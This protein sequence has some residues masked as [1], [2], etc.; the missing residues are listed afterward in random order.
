M[1]THAPLAT[2]VLVLDRVVEQIIAPLAH[3]PQGGLGVVVIGVPQ[4]TRAQPPRRLLLYALQAPILQVLPY[5][6]HRAQAG[7]FVGRGRLPSLRVILAS[8]L[9]E[10]PVPVLN[11]LLAPIVLAQG[12]C[13]H[14]AP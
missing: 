3:I 9:Q 2:T 1:A 10:M 6:V 5:P 14:Y 13:P 4:D 8:I 12:V 11:V 7:H